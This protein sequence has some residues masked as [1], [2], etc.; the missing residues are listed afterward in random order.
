MQ[1]FC[2]FLNEQVMYFKN[3]DVVTWLSNETVFSHRLMFTKCFSALK[4][5]TAKRP[6]GKL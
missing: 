3:I 1:L 4:Q 2:Q 6:D 5:R